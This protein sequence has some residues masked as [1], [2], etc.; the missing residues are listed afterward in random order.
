MT[1]A[2]TAA[3]RRGWWWVGLGLLWFLITPDLPIAQTLL[4][5]HRPLLLLL[6]ALVMCAVLGWW[7][8]GSLPLLL[9][10][11]GGLGWMVWQVLRGGASAGVLSMAWGLLAAGCFAFAV[12]AARSRRFLVAGVVSTLAALVLA[13]AV[14]S[15]TRSGVDVLRSTH[16]AVLE[17]R[18][19]RDLMGL[20][21]VRREMEQSKPSA[22]DTSAMT[23][24]REMTAQFDALE[25]S[26]AR[27]PV[28]ARLVWPALLALQTLAAM[29][30]AWAV[31]HRLSRKPIGEELGRLRDFRFNDHWIWSV[32]LGLTLALLPAL[33]PLRPLGINLLVFFGALYALRGVAVLS[34]FLR[35]GRGVLGVLI[36]LALLLLLRDGAAIALGLVGLGDTWAD[37]R[38]RIRPAVS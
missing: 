34:W 21:A 31:F 2:T 1:D 25:T 28:V 15:A 8:G 35:P 14:V 20:R 7:R 19:A 26:V 3:P 38:R 4:P 24:V 18:S 11:G 37:W 9:A 6:P 27:L 17:D 30:L 10:S 22:S 12:L 32:I 23:A 36:G 13:A 5:V 33:A 29:A 16:Q